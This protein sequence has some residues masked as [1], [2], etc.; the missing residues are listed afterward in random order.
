MKMLTESEASKLLNVSL[1]TLQ[2]DRCDGRLSI[3]FAKI[4]KSVRYERGQVE[5]WL[6]TRVRTT[7][8]APK[9]LHVVPKKKI[10]RPSK[11]DQVARRQENFLPAA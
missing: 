7:L 3:P 2:K 9:S 6:Q 8:K 4:G 10:G 11:A 1:S 5:A